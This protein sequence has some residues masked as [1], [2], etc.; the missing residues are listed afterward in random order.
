M[1]VLRISSKKNGID[2]L[3]RLLLVAV[4]FSLVG[5][6]DGEFEDLQEFV[7]K[8]G[9]ELRGQVDAPPEIKLYEPF[10]YDNSAELPDP[11]KPKEQDSRKVAIEGGLTNQPDFNR[12]KEDLENYPLESLKMIGY[13]QKKKIG[14]A[15]IRSPDGKIYHIKAGNYMGLNFGRIVSVTETEIRL[16]EM[17]QDSG[18]DWIERDN[19]LQLVEK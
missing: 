9:D 13:L 7:K 6:G 10:P 12:P 16:K 2:N 14:N 18:G 3:L 5:C 8:S 1:T 17:V 11:F 19:S 15:I 4:V